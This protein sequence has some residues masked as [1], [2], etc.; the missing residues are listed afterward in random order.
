MIYMN[1]SN[2]FYEEAISG[3]LRKAFAEARAIRI[4]A[5]MTQGFEDTFPD[6]TEK[7]KGLDSKLWQLVESSTRYRR[8]CRTSSTKATQKLVS[9]T[10]QGCT[11]KPKSA[12]RQEAGKRKAASLGSWHADFSAARKALKAEGYKG[13]FSLK[14][15]GPM[16]NKIVS[17]QQGRAAAPAAT[18]SSGATRATPVPLDRLSREP[19]AEPC[20]LHRDSVAEAPADL[21]LQAKRD[22]SNVSVVG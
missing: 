2:E 21:R 14:K 4:Q 16:H 17:L 19:T 8:R 15:G 3:P 1:K 11:Q 10:E 6:L 7:M 18:A 13:S 20:V 9:L 22:G 5:E 12:K